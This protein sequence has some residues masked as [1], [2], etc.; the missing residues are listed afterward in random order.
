MSNKKPTKPRLIAAEAPVR[1]G[2]LR[3]LPRE[4]RIKLTET[5][6]ESAM[7]MGLLDSRQIREWLG[8]TNM[9]LKSIST[10]VRNVKEK[11]VQETSDGYEYARDQRAT[12]I[13]KAWSE[14]R[15]CEKLFLEALTTADKVKVKKLQLE[16]M[17]YVSRLSFVDKLIESTTPDMQIIVNG[18]MTIKEL[19]E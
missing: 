13:K 11:W 6:V 16:W 1:A 10:A 4:D 9:N 2:I 17:Q 12:Q 7:T 3:S 8:D 15:G 18:G 5:L 19:D 14:V